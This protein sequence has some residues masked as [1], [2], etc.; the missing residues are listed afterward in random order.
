MVEGPAGEGGT[1]FLSVL[2]VLLRI[3]HELQS[4]EL[5]SNDYDVNIKKGILILASF[6][7]I[8]LFRL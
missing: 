3:K 4:D 2:T 1:C 8:F 7:H 6:F 5:K